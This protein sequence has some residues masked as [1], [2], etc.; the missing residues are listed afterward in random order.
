MSSMDETLS[1]KNPN[2]EL[3]NI[4]QQ[5][6]EHKRWFL[7]VTALIISS[8]GVATGAFVFLGRFFAEGY[9]Q[10]LGIQSYQVKFAPEDYAVA[11]WLM[12]L[13]FATAIMI[14]ILS[15]NTI[16]HVLDELGIIL[17]GS[18]RKKSEGKYPP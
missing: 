5:E 7:D 14:A 18:L 10:S 8:L 6:Q 16:S 12:P 2:N 3:G 4:K 11:G 13:V 17:E 15:R 1:V 9:F